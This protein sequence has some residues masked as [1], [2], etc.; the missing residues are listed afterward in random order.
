MNIIGV[1]LASLITEADAGGKYSKAS[2]TGLVEMRRKVCGLRMF[3]NGNLQRMLG[4]LGKD[5][6]TS[7][8]IGFRLGEVSRA[9]T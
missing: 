2:G 3:V 6:R 7:I 4:V 8:T 1:L 9:L 5:D